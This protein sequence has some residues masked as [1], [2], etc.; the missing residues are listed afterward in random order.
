MNLNRQKSRISKIVRKVGPRIENWPERVLR[1]TSVSKTVRA[2]F[3]GSQ[4]E[5]EVVDPPPDIETYV[6]L[7]SIRN[8]LLIM[9]YSRFCPKGLKTS[10]E[11]RLF[12]TCFNGAI[13]YRCAPIYAF[14]KKYNLV[15]ISFPHSSA[16]QSVSIA[17][18]SFLLSSPKDGLSHRGQ[19]V[20]LQT[21]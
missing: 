2:L 11:K 12:N 16:Q 14:C 20:T 17:K 5:N 18:N 6:K 19:L 4:R 1:L 9:K 3:A 13:I 8:L 21:V 15:F 7:S 10:K